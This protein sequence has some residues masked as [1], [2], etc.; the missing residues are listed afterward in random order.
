MINKSFNRITRRHLIHVAINCLGLYPVA[1]L[2]FATIAAKLSGDFPDQVSPFMSPFFYPEKKFALIGYVASS[3]TL[4]TFVAINALALNNPLLRRNYAWNERKKSSRNLIFA[5]GI[6]L[7]AWITQFS[8]GISINTPIAILVFLNATFPFARI[9]LNA[10]TKL[11]TPS[12]FSL[13]SKALA[14]LLLIHLCLILP[15]ILIKPIIGNEYYNISSTTKLSDHATDESPTLSDYE[16]ASRFPGIGLRKWNAEIGGYENLTQTYPS[17]KINLTPKLKS[18]LKSIQNTIPDQVD[19]LMRSNTPQKRIGHENEEEERLDYNTVNPLTYDE[20]MGALVAVGPLSKQ[21]AESIKESVEPNDKERIDQLAYDSHL[22]SENQIQHAYSDTEREYIQKNY[23]ELTNQILARRMIHHHNFLFGPI[24]ELHQGRN[25]NEINLQY[26]YFFAASM[27][28]ILT[29]IGDVSFQSYF[30]L[31]YAFY[32]LYFLL[33]I[34]VV[35]RTSGDKKLWLLFSCICLANQGFIGYTALATAPGLN[36]VRHFFDFTTLGLMWYG[37][38]NENKKTYCLSIILV[39]VLCFLAL[40][41]NKQTG[42]F[43]LL[44]TS[45]TFGVKSLIESGIRSISLIAHL[46]VAIAGLTGLAYIDTGKDFLSAYYIMGLCGFPTKAITVFL[47][48]LLTASTYFVLIGGWHTLAKED[49]YLLLACSLYSQAMFIYYIWGGTRHHLMNFIP[50]YAYNAVL[51]IKAS[52]NLSPNWPPTNQ[53]NNA[54]GIVGSLACLLAITGV[55]NYVFEY[56]KFIRSMQQHELHAWN[57]TMAKII[58]P[59]PEK[60]FTDAVNL[61][62]KYND[63]PNIYIISEYDAIIPR[64]ANGYSAMPFP[65]LQWFLNSKDEI[66][67]C[68]KK[69]Q[70]DKPEYLFVDRGIE[71]DF[72]LEVPN[73]TTPIFN[74]LQAEGILRAHRLN[75]VKSIFLANKPEY[76]LIDTSNLINVWKRKSR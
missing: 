63:K 31:L 6:S 29:A 49:K 36:P 67:S 32:P 56:T 33:A 1:A 26:G 58:S 73:S 62:R 30:K 38:R 4:A 28:R 16:A 57:S 45:L 47:F 34:F 75:A 39:Y 11:F 70:N 27:E 37:L 7:L 18:T 24:I 22:W 64:L 54:I 69:I 25:L 10:S 12:G 8:I 50:V 41:N 13:S 44:S 15:L 60:P 55:L 65:D 74:S 42:I 52:S 9:L 71:R 3:A 35:A 59:M 5:L 72:F 40:L 53:R 61:I 46:A 2:A 51:L 66:N 23:S 21:I 76:E 19:M 17:Q 68:I 48:I 43:L 20:S 14:C